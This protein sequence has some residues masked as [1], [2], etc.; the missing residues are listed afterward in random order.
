MKKKLKIY[1]DTSVINFLYYDLAPDYKYST[2]E[3]FENFIAL[4][5]YDTYY[6]VYVIDEINA[7]PDIQKKE[8]LLNTFI[9]YPLKLLEINDLDELQ[10]LAEKYIQKNILP[11]KKYL[12]AL[13]I[14]TSV[15]F[16]IDYLISWNFRHLANVNKERLVNAANLENGYTKEIR[17]ITPLELINYETDN[18]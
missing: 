7:T 18:T 6:S 5:I 14:A 15:I 9:K 3:L 16:G 2:I 4:E 12:D 1:L 11:E 13:H 17:I 8:I 10:N